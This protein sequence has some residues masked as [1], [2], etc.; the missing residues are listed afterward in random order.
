MTWLPMGD[1]AK[2]G[3][4]V[5][6]KGGTWIRGNV[7]RQPLRFPALVMWDGD[8][9]AVCDNEGPRSTVLSPTHWCPMPGDGQA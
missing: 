7:D 4:R 2:S 8:E 9:F 3:D 5:L 6:V 1:E